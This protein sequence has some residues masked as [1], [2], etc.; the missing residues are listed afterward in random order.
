MLSGPGA[1]LLFPGSLELSHL[2]RLADPVAARINT[3]LTD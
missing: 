1:W 3:E 2:V